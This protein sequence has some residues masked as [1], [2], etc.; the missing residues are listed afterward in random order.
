METIIWIGIIFCIS[1]SAM[2]SGLSFCPVNIKN[3]DSS[4][5]DVVTRLKV[6]PEKTGD[7][8]IDEDII[9]YWTNEKRIITGAD[10]L[11]RLLRGIARN[12]VR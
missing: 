10:I 3:V 12:H 2:F 7:D 8:V 9:I 1:Q 5:G 11:G 6:L 4:L